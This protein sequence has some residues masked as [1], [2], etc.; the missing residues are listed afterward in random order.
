[1][2]RLTKFIILIV[3]SMSVYFIYQDN[4]NKTTKI[5]NLGDSLS[6]GINSYGI[7]ECSYVDL[8]KEYL[9][10]ENKKITINSNYSNKE[11]SIK[12]LLEKIKTNP[13]LKRDLSEAHILFLTVGYNDL[14]YQLSIEE[15]LNQNKIDK[16]TK[17]ISNNYKTL[18]EEIRK[19]YKNNIIV[20]GYF[21]SNKEDYYLNYG[22]RKLNNLLET[23]KKIEYIDTYQL[24]SNRKKYF[25]NPN[26]YYP[27]L[28]G[29]QAITKKIIEKTLE[30]QENI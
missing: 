4:Y 3:L 26:S 18:L 7:K 19:Y 22:I 17:E 24:A 11:L 10:K 30:K 20:I 13:K 28:E 23:T 27:N 8:Y 15:N 21:P 2:N 29:Y 12:E 6:L 16:I 14:L 5:L 1:M 25:S 9:K